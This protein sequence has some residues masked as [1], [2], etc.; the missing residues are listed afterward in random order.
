MAM[1]K[2]ITEVSELVEK[3]YGRAGARFG[4]TNHS[5]H[6]SYAIMLEELEEAQADVESLEKQMQ[7]FWLFVKNNDSADYKHERLMAVQRS[8]L[9][10]ACE[11][12]QVAAMAKKAA[13][14][15][16]DREALSEICNADVMPN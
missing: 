4:L 7:I 12:I 3:E 6:E 8:A 14:T 9:L 16:C 15:L 5:D 11:F 10:A 2:L 1:Q 13:L